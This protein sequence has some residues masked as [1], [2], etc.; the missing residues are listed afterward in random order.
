MADGYGFLLRWIDDTCVQDVHLDGL[1][2]HVCPVAVQLTGTVVYSSLGNRTIAQGTGYL[3]AKAHRAR[4]WTAG[5]TERGHRPVVAQQFPFPIAVVAVEDNV[6]P[7]ERSSDIH[8][9]MS[10]CRFLSGSQ[11]QVLYCGCVVPQQ[12]ACILQYL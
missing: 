9:L 1:E 11:L 6:D 5:R 7:H 12:T 4:V 10:Y 8:V 3:K 2:V